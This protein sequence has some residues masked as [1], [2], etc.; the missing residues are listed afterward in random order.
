MSGITLYTTDASTSTGYR[1]ATFDE[2]MI[3]ARQ[4]VS[5]KVRRGT[6]LTSPQ[7]T[8]NYL[9]ARLAQHPYEMFTLIYLDNRHRLIACQELFRGTID[10]ASVHPREVVREALKH[11]AA[12]VILAHNHPLCCVAVSPPHPG[13]TGAVKISRLGAAAVSQ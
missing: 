6:T 10:G 5:R 8:A 1:E 7:A 2:I 4:A 13:V 3:G 9:M 12:A 11:N